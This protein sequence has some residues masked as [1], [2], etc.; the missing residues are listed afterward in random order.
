MADSGQ[1][2]LPLQFDDPR[3]ERIFKRLSELSPGLA[4]FFYDACVLMARPEELKSTRHVVAHLLRDVESG[5][6]NAITPQPQDR[7]KNEKGH[8]GH[9]D[10]ILKLLGIDLDHPIAGLWKA[11]TGSSSL[12]GE[13]HRDALEAPRPVND[14]FRRVWNEMQGVFD[15]VLQRLDAHYLGW[16]AELDRLLATGQPAE[17]DA[18]FLRN[19][20]P[21]NAV[22]RAYFFSRLNDLQ[23]LEPLKRKGFFSE[24]PDAVMHEDG[25]VSFPPWPQAEYLARMAPLA[26]REVHD[27][28]MEMPA[29]GNEFVHEALVEA[30]LALPPEVA[31]AWV[32]KEADWVGTRDQLFSPLPQLL[33]KLG[34]AMLANGRCDLGLKLFRTLLSIRPDPAW[35]YGKDADESEFAELRTPR[36]H[37]RF[38]AYEYG[39]LLRQHAERIV[40]ACE[41]N[42]VLLLCECLERAI[43]YSSRRGADAKPNDLSQIRYPA[44]DRAPERPRE[45]PEA[46]LIVAVRD[47][48]MRLARRSPR[49]AA[50]VLE[51]LEAREWHI[52]RRIALHLIRTEPEALSAAVVA[53]LS[54]P[55][56][57]DNYAYRYEY[58]ALQREQFGRLSAE[59]QAEFLAFVERGPDIDGWSARF[60]DERDRESSD[61]DRARRLSYWRRDQLEPIRAYLVGKW[62]EVYDAIV[63]D[64]GAP[65]EGYDLPFRTE[66]RWGYESPMSVDEMQRASSEKVVAF[67]REWVPP[68]GHFGPTPEGLG[69]TLA[70][71]VKSGPERW[72][73]AL[74]L[75]EGVEPTYARCLLWG[76][77]ESLQTT[78]EV[79]WV[80]IL[81]FC[82]WVVLQ[83]DESLTELSPSVERDTTW[84]EARVALA[85]LLQTGLQGKVNASIPPR[86]REQVWRVLRPLTND[87]DPGDDTERK[88]DPAS[89]DP[90]T[91]SI[92]SVRGIALHA[93]L[94]YAAWIRRSQDAEADAGELIARGFDEMSE[95]REVLD[96]HLDLERERSAAIRA[97]Y[98][99]RYTELFVLDKNWTA[100]NS[101]KVFLLDDRLA[102]VWEAAWIAYLQYNEPYV[103]VFATLVQ[104]YARG[105]DRMGSLP[106]VQFA[107]EST[108]NR[109]AAHLVILAEAGAL[110]ESPA[111]DSWN[112]FWVRAAESVRAYLYTYSARNV[113]LGDSSK[114]RH[115]REWLMSLWDERS[116][117]MLA[118]PA[119]H[120][121]E[122]AAFGWWF[123]VGA[124]PM[125]W[126]LERLAAVANVGQRLEVAHE[127]LPK[128]ASAAAEY[129]RLAVEIL[130]AVVASG[131]AGW[132]VVSARESVR[133]I[134]AAAVDAGDEA[135]R[136]AARSTIGRLASQGRLEFRDLLGDP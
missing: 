92:N 111:A 103:D 5:L 10:V 83:T 78:T 6:R 57:F 118:S 21:N 128:L 90:V 19:N 61:E 94:D 50:R 115:A 58:K 59:Q 84:R 15:G 28:M 3:Q 30:A 107:I 71:A 124:F 81:D 101:N 25:G 60:R 127:V 39:E 98:G 47:A 55:T 62:A 134:L 36:P 136:A 17:N 87:P 48:A 73:A 96:A 99:M 126:R 80:R 4:S 43:E 32:D 125:K 16:L 27:V 68:K 31:A 33:G 49:D 108:D 18:K 35:V 72:V 93:L 70:E 106:E 9:I 130:A 114:D 26:P 119:D 102:K 29:T 74:S 51:Y 133:G 1:R 65:E 79:D 122:L 24:P 46:A 82:N 117:A 52:F 64:I 76:L 7:Q 37:V 67:L 56:Y 23:W 95:V 131:S 121:E 89:L 110:G 45:E 132:A 109:L 12:S 44:V 116:P 8:A 123:I 34:A 129:P 105:V 77:R 13:A 22:T 69:R 63:A 75:F 86:L 41:W 120:Q 38:N 42:G 85:H 14:G 54:D 20:V 112:N 104:Q 113:R 66:S 11:Y 88:R 53:R 2:R 100:L 97:V 135:A 40:E 91:L